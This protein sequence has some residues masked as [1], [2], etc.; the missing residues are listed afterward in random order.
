MIESLPSIN[1]EGIN[2]VKDAAEVACFISLK[3]KKLE[4]LF[5][6]QCCLVI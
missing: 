2:L 5:P 6:F 3:R 4:M 1:V